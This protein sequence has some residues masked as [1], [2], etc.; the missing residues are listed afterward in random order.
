MNYCPILE[1]ILIMNGYYKEL[2]IFSK[3]DVKAI[4]YLQEMMH[5]Y[6]KQRIHK[7]RK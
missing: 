4:P 6:L 5:S 7:L 2:N 1:N 3:K